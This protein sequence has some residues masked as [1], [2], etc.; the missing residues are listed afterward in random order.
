M[1]LL[2]LFLYKLF[3]KNRYGIGTRLDR[4]VPEAN[5]TEMGNFLYVFSSPLNA[6]ICTVT[7]RYKIIRLHRIF[8]R[9]EM[10]TNFNLYDL[11]GDVVIV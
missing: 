6:D 2:E 8:M 5:I 10:A 3:N 7:I 9:V 11:V 1:F 4:G